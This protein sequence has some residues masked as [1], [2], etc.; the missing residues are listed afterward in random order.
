MTYFFFILSGTLLLD[1]CQTI[2]DTLYYTITY[3]GYSFNNTA[4]VISA[5]HKTQIPRTTHLVKTNFLL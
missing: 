4:A 5:Q 2:H 1:S 3:G